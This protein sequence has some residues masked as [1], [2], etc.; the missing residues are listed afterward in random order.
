MGAQ[1]LQMLVGMYVTI[2]AVLHQVTGQ[3][4][5]VKKTNSVLG[6]LMYL[7]YFLLFFKLFVD[8]YCWK[9]KKQVLPYRASH[10]SRWGQCAKLLRKHLTQCRRMCMHIRKSNE[11][12]ERP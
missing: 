4:C 11:I 7:S 12:A 5:H 6:L 10:L 9:S 8:N 1:L 3:E 2:K